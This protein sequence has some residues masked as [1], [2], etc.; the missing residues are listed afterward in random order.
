[1]V[2]GCFLIRA[3]SI[4]HVLQATFHFFQVDLQRSCVVNSG[5]ESTLSV[6]ALCLP[7]L[8]AFSLIRHDQVMIM[9]QYRRPVTSD[10][11]IYGSALPSF[12]ATIS[13]SAEFDQYQ[14]DLQCPHV[15]KAS[16]RR[17]YIVLFTV[18]H[19]YQAS[20][21]NLKLSRC[22]ILEKIWHSLP[23]SR[24]GRHHLSGRA[25]RRKCHVKGKFLAG[26]IA[27]AL[28]SR[29]RTFYRQIKHYMH[30]PPPVSI[31]PE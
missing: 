15:V 25:T 17:E 27:T 21:T 3:S 24:P 20:V 14:H 22:V 30:T 23:S 11:R 6:F 18:P 8:V 13:P 2:T 1:M 31:L 7:R 16:S 19:N 5:S 29:Q 12:R 26:Q 10:T 28:R 9:C 4:F